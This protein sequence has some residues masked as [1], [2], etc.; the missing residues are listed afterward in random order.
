MQVLLRVFLLLTLLSTLMVTQLGAE[1]LEDK[2][3]NWLDVFKLE[4]GIEWPHKVIFK[5]DISVARSFVLKDDVGLWFLFMFDE[6]ILADWTDQELRALVAHEVAHYSPTCY[7]WGVF[8]AQLQMVE[9]CADRIGS[10]LTSRDDMI[11][12]LKKT[13]GTGLSM[14]QRVG[15]ADR[16]LHLQQL[17]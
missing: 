13:N 4:L 3:D 6:V 16:V 12:G 9:Y 1:P 8:Q 11:A 10:Q 2:L 17:P 5:S 7:M 15:L 14:Q